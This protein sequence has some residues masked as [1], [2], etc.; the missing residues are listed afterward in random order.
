MGSYQARLKFQRD[1]KMYVQD[2]HDKGLKEGREACLK[3]GIAERI[4]LC[5]QLLKTP[6]TPRE[7][8]LLLPIEEL[9]AAAAALEAQLG[10]AS[11]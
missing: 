10:V 11:R 1:Q 2:A 9:H 5:Q 3:E 6:I 8:L 7:D 4:R